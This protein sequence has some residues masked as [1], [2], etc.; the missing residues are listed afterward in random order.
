MSAF[1]NVVPALARALVN[2]GYDALTPVQE[3]ITEPG[4]ETS[5][6]IVSAQTGSGKTVAFGMAL[7]P[8]L[9]DG[10]DRLAPVDTPL[11]LVIAPTRELA[12]QVKA[13]LTWLYEPAGVQ[14]AS[15]VGGMDQQ[16]ERRS[17]R[18]GPHIVVGTP[19]RLSDHIRRGSLVLDG[20]KAVVLDEADEMLNLGFREEL[21]FILEA[22]PEG[23]RTLMFSAT[24]PK[25]IES[26]AR[27]YQ[28]DA[29]RVNTVSGEP[30]HADIEYRAMVVASHE[31][32]NAI[33]NVLRFYDAPNALVFCST[34][35]A[36]T[37]MM[38]RFTN[39][40]FAAVALSG[41]LSQAQRTHALQALRDHRAQVCIA[42]DVAARGIDL[43]DLELVIH[44][45]LPKSSETLLHR[46]GRTGRAGRKGTCVVIVP[47][48]S[49]RNAE[50]LLKNAG[51]EAQWVAPPSAKD[52]QQRDDERLLADPILYEPIQREERA[53]LGTLMGAYDA[54]QI[55][56]AFVRLHRKGK[57]AGEDLSAVPDVVERE[58]PAPSQGARDAN[59]LRRERIISDGPRKAPRNN[60]QD[61]VWISLGV[62]RLQYA[63]PRW[64]IPVLCDA[65]EVTKRSIG[66]IRIEDND[67]FVELEPGGADEFL[68]NLEA[69]GRLDR[70]L[71]VRRLAAEPV[72]SPAA[73]TYA[74]ERDTETRARKPRHE[75]PQV[76]R[77]ASDKPRE[78]RP[79]RT[80]PAIVE[81]APA[82]V[83]EHV[84]EQ[85]EQPR[86]ENR[87][88]RR[89]K[90]RAE[91]E[92]ALAAGIEPPKRAPV[93]AAVVA[94]PAE[95]PTNFEKRPKTWKGAK[96][97]HKPGPGGP[98]AKPFQKRD[99]KPFAAR[100]PAA[101]AQ[102]GKK[103][104]R[105]EG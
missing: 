54:E 58:R 52:V 17:L 98:K 30:Q 68:A 83:R 36:V 80:P 13:E 7:A 94:K 11:A 26:L 3:A 22:S 47:Q 88:E 46:S 77:P 75:K 16:E 31:A 63:E 86:T 103:K 12:M 38:T 93:Q 10:A 65:G 4:L 40:G 23:R 66:A 96:P 2:R 79:E 9:L 57:S 50:R 14:I 59:P 69:R 20:L 90:E 28:R 24:M 92:A 56:A 85:T 71:A 5:D 33:F 95:R 15:C 42:T 100:G 49:R 45:E 29:V 99:G 19:G 73:P 44:A 35:A 51:V 89:A 55:A 39:R 87:K 101:A 97:G 21:E 78:R 72:L 41:E 27:K 67:T 60:F 81:R 37:R 32:E 84:V 74:P 34:R 62:G 104:W 76:E 82:L 25:A 105:P 1:E 43:A 48:K 61:G 8:Q 91:R 53:F 64:I 18:R 6:L 70:G 102:G